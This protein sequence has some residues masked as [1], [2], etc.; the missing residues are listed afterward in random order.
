[1]K[2]SEFSRNG[3]SFCIMIGSIFF[4]IL[5]TIWHL[6]V[7][8]SIV[9][10]IIYGFINGICS[11]RVRKVS[12]CVYKE[13]TSRCWSSSYVKSGSWIRDFYC[14]W[15]KYSRRELFNEELDRETGDRAWLNSWLFNVSIYSL[16]A[17]VTIYFVY[18][19]FFSY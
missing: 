1:M 14:W 3:F 6:M 2:D 17:L 13:C 5:L 15:R 18:N 7:L 11:C 12:W 19:L 8:Y 10:N 4:R 9:L 16:R